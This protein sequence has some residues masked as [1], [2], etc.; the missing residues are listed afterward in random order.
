MPIAWFLCPYKRRLDSIRPR[1][2]CAMDDF[3]TQIGTDGGQWSESEI[4]GNRAIVKVRASDAT[5]TT[6]ASTAIFRRIPLTRLDDSLSTL[7]GAQRNAIR[8]EIVDA[9]YTSAEL[10]AAIPNLATATLGQV[11]RFMATR[12]LK[13]RYDAATDAIIIDGPI[14]SVK[15]A[16]VVDAAVT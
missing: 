12:R 2:Y 5:L 16:D 4:L 8:Q 6:I 1:R 15:S 13:P 11:L 7:T 3:T 9:G 14:Q 10:N